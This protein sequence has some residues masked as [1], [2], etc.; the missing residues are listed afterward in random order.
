[1]ARAPLPKGGGIKGKGGIAAGSKQF[2]MDGMS[3]VQK[4][5]KQLPEKL[6]DRALK[7]AMAAGMRV[8]RDEAKRLV[9]VGPG[10]THLKD[11]I[12]V[13]RTV[14]RG[15]KRRTLK[16]EV[17]LGIRDEGRY[18]A[19]LVELGASHMDPQ[20]FMRPALDN[21][22]KEALRVVGPKLGK[23]I[24]KQAGKLG[25]MSGSKR[26]KAFRRSG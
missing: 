1:M 25:K 22:A 26:R 13:S 4:A 8:I 6:Q 14:Q 5:L 19:H 2:G 7:N 12:V 11:M 23:E 24:E 9:P 15:G 21:K 18:Y 3:E 17:V 16:G 20:P 10:P